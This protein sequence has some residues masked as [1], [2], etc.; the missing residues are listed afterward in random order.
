MNANI[1]M[2]FATTLMNSRLLVS[3]ERLTRQKFDPSE[4][5]LGLEGLRRSFYPPLISNTP[6][7]SSGSTRVPRLLLEKYN[8]LQNEIDKVTD[9]P[10]DDFYDDDQDDETMSRSRRTLRRGKLR[11]CRRHSFKINVTELGWDD[12]IIY[13]SEFDAHYC[14]GE[15]SYPID[16][17]QNATNHAIIQSLYHSMGLGDVPRTCCSP[18]KLAPQY[19]L[20]YDDQDLKLR[21]FKDM[22]VA[23]C[24]CI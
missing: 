2:L 8:K 11:K 19:F 3:T 17:H 20:I 14:V 6:T 24:G 9:D 16:D 12:W 22:T 1:I 7:D 21:L 23:H 10:D 5:R 4:H 13:P 15:C 18:I